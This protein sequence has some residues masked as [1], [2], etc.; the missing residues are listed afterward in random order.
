[1]LPLT[2]IVQLCMI[3]STK[4][5]WTTWFHQLDLFSMILS[6]IFSIWFRITW[7]T[8]LYPI[9][10]SSQCTRAR[11][12]S[13]PACILLFPHFLFFNV[14]H[15]RAR[16]R[17]RGCSSIMRSVTG[18]GAVNQMLTFAH[19]GGRGGTVNDHSILIMHRGGGA[20]MITRSL[21]FFLV[22]NYRKGPTCIYCVLFWTAICSFNMIYILYDN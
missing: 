4:V 16:S 1:M 7:S 19:K 11:H 6:T 20:K 13:A 8:Q 10:S 3:C 18:E 14:T 12:S 22:W 5:I 21:Y 9:N 2:W 17:V 15:C